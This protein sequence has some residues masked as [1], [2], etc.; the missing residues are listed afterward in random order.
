MGVIGYT[1]GVFDLFHIGHLNLIRAAKKRCDHLIVGVHSD[2]VVEGYK[3][4]RPIVSDHDRRQIVASIR[5]VDEAVIN[6]TRDKLALWEKYHFDVVF[7]GDDW[8]NTERWKH[9][10][11][12]LGQVGVRVEY[13]P[14]THGVSTTLL[15]QRIMQQHMA[16]PA[17]D[18]P[19]R[20]A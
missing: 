2:A 17:E 4:Q 12:V 8:K 6:E 11:A 9:F 3:H 18:Q 20:K 19:I 14:Y 1:D 7:I 15:R 10:E 13:L 16:G 5:E